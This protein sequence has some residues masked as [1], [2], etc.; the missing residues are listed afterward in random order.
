VRQRK[1]SKRQHPPLKEN[2]QS[3]ICQNL[4][5]PHWGRKPHPSL[6]RVESPEAEAEK[7]ALLIGFKGLVNGKNSRAEK[8]YAS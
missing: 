3:H 7:T 6:K 5:G 8:L 2:A 1:T 4:Y